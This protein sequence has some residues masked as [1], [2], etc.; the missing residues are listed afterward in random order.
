MHVCVECVIGGGDVC[1]RSSTP[2]ENEGPHQRQLG[3]SLPVSINHA[4]LYSRPESQAERKRPI[5][6]QHTTE[7]R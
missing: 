1:F 6:S 4:A 3:G 5:M 2:Q 7:V